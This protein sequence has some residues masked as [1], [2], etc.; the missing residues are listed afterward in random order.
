MGKPRR[1]KAKKV[2]K[3]TVLQPITEEREIDP[4]R[5]AQ[6]AFRWLEQALPITD[7]WQL[8]KSR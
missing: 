2:Y 3:L 1:S 4:K 7:S 6:D 8:E 5:S